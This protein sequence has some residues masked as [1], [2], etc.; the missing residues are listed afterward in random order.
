MQ[1]QTNGQLIMTAQQN[2]NVQAFNRQNKICPAAA[3]LRSLNSRKGQV[4]MASLLSVTARI[5]GQ[6]TGVPMQSFLEYDWSKLDRA[7]IQAILTLLVQSGRAPATVNTYLYCLRGVMLESWSLGYITHEQYIHCKT[8]KGVRGS[9]LSRRKLV[10]QDQLHELLQVCAA[11]RSEIGLRDYAI[12]HLMLATG[13]RRSEVVALDLADFNAASAEMIVMGKGNKERIA[14]LPGETVQLL[15][16][17]IDQVRGEQPGALFYRIRKA[18]Q[19]TS[20]RLSDKAIYYLLNKRCMEA[21]LEF[22][23]P[24]DL[25]A[26]FGTM[27]LNG[28]TDLLV[29]RDTLGHASVTTT[30]GYIVRD[31]TKHREAAIKQGEMLRHPDPAPDIAAQ[32]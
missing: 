27:L 11:D 8:I 26:T 12:F 9:R 7:K 13:L 5:I 31:N 2:G 4:A 16:N 30:E 3:Y 1:N 14:Y 10:S 20:E 23:S 6:Q 15:E 29:V 28:G 18:G 22:F 19:V 17:W 32:T 25:R 24:H 21:G